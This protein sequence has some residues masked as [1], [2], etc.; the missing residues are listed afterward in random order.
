MLDTDCD[1]CQYEG[2][3]PLPD[4]PIAPSPIAPSPIA[5]EDTGRGTASEN[6]RRSLSV[7]RRVYCKS[8]CRRAPAEN[9]RSHPHESPI[10]SPVLS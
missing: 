10:A 8:Y 1:N 5:P 9:E 7:S 3:R 6:Y 2:D 4:R